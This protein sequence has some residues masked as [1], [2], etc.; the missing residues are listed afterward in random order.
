MLVTECSYIA[1]IAEGISTLPS[2]GETPATDVVPSESTEYSQVRRLPVPVHHFFSAISNLS[3]LAHNH[4]R[5]RNRANRHLL[6]STTAICYTKCHSPS[7]GE[8]RR[9]S[10]VIN[11]LQS[12]FSCRVLGSRTALAESHF[13]AF[14]TS[15]A[16]RASLRSGEAASSRCPT[17]ETTD[18]PRR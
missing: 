6:Q 10:C 8:R 12:S 7:S 16:R 4:Q 5:R 17:K 13:G 11:W 14:L 1:D 18:E 15:L 9:E 3:F 2:F